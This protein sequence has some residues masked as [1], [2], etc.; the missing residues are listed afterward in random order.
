MG[1]VILIKGVYMQNVMSWRPAINIRSLFLLVVL[2]VGMFAAFTAEAA[3]VTCRTITNVPQVG[4][5][6]DGSLSNYG[7]AYSAQY[8]VPGSSVSGCIHINVTNV[9]SSGSGVPAED[10]TCGWFRVRFYPTSG[11]N[12]ATSWVKRC[13]SSSQVVA[14]ATDVINGTRYRVEWGERYNINTVFNVRD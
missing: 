14:I 4:S 10:A 1:G 2:T 12:Y 9:R 8:T 6:Q 13:A 5:F 3:A 11:G 7:I